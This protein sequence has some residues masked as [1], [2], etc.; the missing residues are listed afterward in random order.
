[1]FDSSLNGKYH[2]GV[3]EIEDTKIDSRINFLGKCSLKIK[4]I[5]LKNIDGKEVIVLLKSIIIINKKN[6]STKNEWYENKHEITKINKRIC[7]NN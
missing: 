5:K 4:S 3:T 1:M 2:K 6:K 7:K